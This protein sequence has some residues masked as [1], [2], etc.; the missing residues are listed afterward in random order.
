M[1]QE[2][3]VRGSGE[4]RGRAG[5]GR[6]H[7]PRDLG[8]FMERF[9]LLRI[10]HWFGLAGLIGVV[11]G[12]GALL[13]QWI[14]EYGLL[15]FWGLIVGYVPAGPGGE[16]LPLTT[17]GAEP[18]AWALVVVPAL[19]ALCSAFFVY[20]Y[21]PEAEGHGTD[22]A[23]HA[24]HQ[25][26]GRVRAVT[27]WVKLIA[28]AFT[29]ASG[30]SAGREGP[31]AQIGSGFGS[32]LGT[33]LGLSDR[34]RRILLMAGM[35]AGVGAIFRA[36][37]AG[38]LF[39]TEVLYSEPDIEFE[40]VIPALISSI[41]SYSIFCSV[42]G[43]GHLFSGTQGFAFSEP[44]A[45]LPY[46]VLGIVVALGSIAYV[47]FFD[48]TTRVFS[49]LSLPRMSRP[50]LGAAL[51]GA[52][53]LILWKS[54]GQLESLA[55]LG[56]G[57]GLLQQAVAAEG[58]L[59][60]SLGLVL[61]VA[62]GKIVTTSLTIG[63]GGSGGV[64]GP[65]MVIGGLLGAVV[66]GLFHQWWPEVVPEIGPFTIVGMAGFF[67]GVA[68]TPISTLLMV[69]DMTG[70]YSLL[71]PS[72]L[73]VSIALFLGHRWTIYPEQVRTRAD[74]PAHRGEFLMD[75]L[76]DLQVGQVYDPERE[77]HTLRSDTPLQ[78]IMDLV[79]GTHQQFFPVV[80]GEKELVG[81]VSLEDLREVFYEEGLAGLVVAQDI[82][83]PCALTVTPDDTLGRALQILTVQDV[84]E[85][86]VVA[87]VDSRK[88]LGLITRRDI[89]AAYHRRLARL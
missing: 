81:I 12:L 26:R 32:W 33:T 23:I 72:M 50:V 83:T 52:L 76:G 45:L 27:P 15:L 25:Q 89:I 77:L 24:Y 2:P 79:V 65:S 74:S 7:V 86:P 13:F 66:G 10:W 75:V 18:R 40:V 30:G 59:G 73:V 20:R 1:K 57:Y 11:A 71:I 4:L 70:N 60:V 88:L 51:A 35:A 8:G 63:S 44:A 37:L 29:L 6:F 69:G 28:S 78:A 5:L 64:F 36:P 53:G 39:A 80:R 41:V 48:G 16:H 56:S 49:R 38:A 87:D 43:F 58:V 46:G 68:N 17:P 47:I 85:L 42:H 22:R 82:A 54:T 31:I 55:V 62:L 3:E 34:D 14:T 84:E 21:A 61:L 67:A 9:N 19:G